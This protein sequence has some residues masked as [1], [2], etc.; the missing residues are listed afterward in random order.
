MKKIFL[1]LAL[2]FMLFEGCGVLDY[3]RVEK[4][5]YTISNLDTLTLNYVKNDPGNRDNGIIYPS[6]RA[7]IAERTIVQYDS[8]VERH[9]PNFIR[10]GLFEGIGTWGGD[11]DYSLGTGLFG[12]F[13]ELINLDGYFESDDSF[14]FPGGIYRFGIGEWRLRWF[15]DA[16]NW[17]LGFHLYEAIIPDG[18]DD[19]ILQSVSTPYIRKRFFLREEIPYVAIT[20]A[21]GLGWFPSGYINGSV[22]LDVGSIGGLNMRVYA[23]LAQSI[24][25]SDI[26]NYVQDKSA[27][28][29][30]YFGFGMSFLDFHNLPKETEIEWKHHEHSSWNVGLVQV[31]IVGSNAESSIFGRNDSTSSSI[32][33]GTIIRIAPSELALPLFDYKLFAGTALLNFVGLGMTEWGLGVLPIRI[34]YWDQLLKDEL[35][36]S[37]FIEYNYYP[38]K[39]VHIG[40]KLSLKIDEFFSVNFLLGY[41]NGETFQSLP[42]AFLDN[43]EKPGSLDN[44]YF[45]LS[46]GIRD[47]LF[48]P[49]ELRYNR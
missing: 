27:I 35:F 33:S 19:M 22:S 2:S 4:D 38:S 44:F 3:S 48:A 17:T 23:G 21:V 45:G 29:Y 1:T 12:I 18:R 46:I 43:Y 39:I 10:L 7:V 14:V 16:K 32:S 41:V 24:W 15:R 30:P 49:E 25:S 13:P 42:D 31:G 5:T 20:T 36:I 40:N 28:T 47:R 6:S 9:Y 34:G 37:P 26:G 8:T 11:G